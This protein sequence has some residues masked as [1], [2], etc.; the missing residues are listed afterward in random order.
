MINSIE[1]MEFIDLHSRLDQSDSLDFLGVGI[2]EVQTFWRRTRTL[3]FTLK[4]RSTT[5]GSTWVRRREDGIWVCPCL[6]H[7]IDLNIAIL[8]GKIL[9]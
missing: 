3:E 8:M 6:S 2:A 9:C 4:W 1:F 7:R 5:P